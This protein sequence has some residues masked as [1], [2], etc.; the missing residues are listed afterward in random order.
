MSEVLIDNLSVRRMLHMVNSHS[1]DYKSDIHI[2]NYLNA[3]ILWDDILTIKNR[4]HLYNP[5][6]TDIWFSGDW[7]SGIWGLKENAAEKMLDITARKL[8]INR[9]PV[10]DEV[11]YSILASQIADDWLISKDIVENSFKLQT[12]NDTIFY[13]LIGCNLEKNVLLSSERADF[14]NQ[15]GITDKIFSRLDIMNL[16]NS[17]VS[18]YYNEI[19]KSL[20]KNIFKLENPLLIDY[21]CSSATD[22]KDAIFIAT[23]LRKE[24]DVIALRKALDAIDIALNTGNMVEFRQHI[25]NISEIVNQI[26]K[27]EKEMKSVKINVS[28]TPALSVPIAVPV[29]KIRAPKKKMLNLNFLYHLAEYGLKG[30]DIK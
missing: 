1:K 30:K 13:L 12:I 3:L 24:K 23:Q 22:L 15:T 19:N 20:G 6:R 2:Q 11:R 21:I 16:I 17:D 14:A 27:S 18:N 26:T 28:I 9:I 8:Q 4:S 5:H 25:N 29:P 7:Y 10:N